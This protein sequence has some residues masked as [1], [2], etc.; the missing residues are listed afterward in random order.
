MLVPVLGRPANV[1]RLLRSLR[2]ASSVPHSVLFIVSPR[3]RA[4]QAAVKQAGVPYHQVSW[5]PGRG[6][7]ARKLER[8]RELTS[9]PLLLLA[10]DD[11]HFHPG[12]DTALLRDWRRYDVGVLGTNDLGNPLV[13]RGMH[14][15]HP[16]VV[17]EYAD[18]HGTI[19]NKELMLHPGYDHQWADNELVETA[20]SRGCWRFCW[21]SVVEHLHPAWGKAMRDQTY[22]KA[23]REQ[24]ADRRMFLVRRRLWRKQGA[25]MKLPR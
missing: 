7:W 12:W 2:S 1:A 14:S 18:C 5:P 10:A 8:G 9:E 16:C 15:T 6:D 3:D 23:N 24:K 20:M 19:D 11:L 22:D 17:R 21:D 4:E 13:K 25:L